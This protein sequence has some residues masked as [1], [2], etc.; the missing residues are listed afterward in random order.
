MLQ[1]IECKNN[2]VMYMYTNL[3][4]RSK[5]GCVGSNI[6]CN[7]IYCDHDWVMKPKVHD[8][9][10][11]IFWNCMYVNICVYVSLFRHILNIYFL[12]VRE[13]ERERLCEF[14]VYVRSYLYRCV[15]MCTWMCLCVGLQVHVYNVRDASFQAKAW[16][17]ALAIYFQ[18]IC[19]SFVCTN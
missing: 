8:I 2:V 12:S 1:K 19:F 11:V 4:S 15:Y 17:Q 14:V 13:R 18:A 9:F 3:K 7:I 6:C 5:C 16:I 10:C